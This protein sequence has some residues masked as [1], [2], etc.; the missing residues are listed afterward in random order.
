LNQIPLKNSKKELFPFLNSLPFLIKTSFL[1]KE[2]SGEEYQTSSILQ[3]F[4]K[5]TNNFKRIF[6]D[7]LS[8]M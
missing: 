2:N 3:T 5:M 1:F 8:H 6:R 7:Y 4:S